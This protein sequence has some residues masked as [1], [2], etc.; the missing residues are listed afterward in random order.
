MSTSHFFVIPGYPLFGD[1]PEL[2]PNL[3]V[4]S[5]RS[6]GSEQGLLGHFLGSDLGHLGAPKHPPKYPGKC[7]IPPGKYPGKYPPDSSESDPG[8]SS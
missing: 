7:P 1:T 4:N 5:P 8:M 6:G 2:P 3:R